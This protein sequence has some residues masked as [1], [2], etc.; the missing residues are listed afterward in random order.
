MLHEFSQNRDG[1]ST[2]YVS[3]HYLTQDKLRE[4]EQMKSFIAL[5]T[6]EHDKH[7]F[8]YFRLI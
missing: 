1:S 6:S 2:C 3:S 8:I 7:S 4:N 5:T